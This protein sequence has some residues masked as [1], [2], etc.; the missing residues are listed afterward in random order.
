MPW[1]YT[2]SWTVSWMHFEETKY[3]VN[4]QGLF[5]EYIEWAELKEEPY[6]WIESLWLEPRTLNALL[7]VNLFSLKQLL[8]T[9]DEE[10]VK[11]KWIWKRALRDIEDKLHSYKKSL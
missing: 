4:K 10:L 8:G 5:E 7:N 3:K 11:I 9:N 6:I 2:W 1:K